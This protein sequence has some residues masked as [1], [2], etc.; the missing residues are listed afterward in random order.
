MEQT[1]TPPPP[2][3]SSFSRGGKTTV[4]R[5]SFLAV[6]RTVSSIKPYATLPYFRRIFATGMRNLEKRQQLNVDVDNVK[7]MLRL[8]FGINNDMV[9]VI[10]NAAAVASAAMVTERGLLPGGGGMSTSLQRQ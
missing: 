4:R 5:Q 2:S 3:S 8:C 10:A 1:L 7:G 9:Q 6:L